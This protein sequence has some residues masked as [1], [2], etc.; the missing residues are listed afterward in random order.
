MTAV[1]AGRIRFV[2]IRRMV[3]IVDSALVFRGF[4][5]MTIECPYR[6][7]TEDAA[8]EPDHGNAF[9]HTQNLQQIVQQSHNTPIG[10]F[11][12]ALGRR[13]LFTIDDA[14]ARG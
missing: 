1:V 11:D 2:A 7:V 3:R 10:L 12:T 5:E 14:P 6:P 4:I 9:E 8:Y 13:R